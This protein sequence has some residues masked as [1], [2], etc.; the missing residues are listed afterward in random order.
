MENIGAIMSD[1]KVVHNTD[2]TH[3]DTEECKCPIKTSKKLKETYE[4]LY[5]KAERT[6]K[7]LINENA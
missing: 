6:L 1:T 7:K 2:L 5:E 3:E 4:R